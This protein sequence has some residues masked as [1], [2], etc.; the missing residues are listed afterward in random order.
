MAC[1][2]RPGLE[3]GPADRAAPNS[4]PSGG[5]RMTGFDLGSRFLDD[6]GHLHGLLRTGARQ[7]AWAEGSSTTG[8]GPLE[9]SVVVQGSTITSRDIDARI[10]TAMTP[11]ASLEAPLP[12]PVDANQGDDESDNSRQK[13]GHDAFDDVQTY[14]LNRLDCI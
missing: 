6:S 5:L 13:T 1:E 10:A 11:F 7:A 3:S 2:E 4:G 14:R 12:H 8:S 9:S